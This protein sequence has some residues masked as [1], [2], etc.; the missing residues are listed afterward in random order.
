MAETISYRKQQI[1]RVVQSYANLVLQQV[2][3]VWVGSDKEYASKLR[4]E[5]SLTWR[6]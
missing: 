1:K 2:P 5:E 3:M 4:L 6:C